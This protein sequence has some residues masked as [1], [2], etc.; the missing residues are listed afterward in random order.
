MRIQL[1]ILEKPYELQLGVMMRNNARRAEVTEA[2]G[3]TS[4]TVNDMIYHY[5]RDLGS[6]T[7]VYLV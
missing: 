4:T 7:R 2:L 3:H 1:G 6:G 5:S